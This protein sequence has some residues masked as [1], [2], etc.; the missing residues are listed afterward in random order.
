[1]LNTDNLKRQTAEKAVEYLEDNS[2][3]GLGTGSTFIYALKYIADMLNRG[4]LKNI[5]GIPSSVTTAKNAQKFGIT[6][7]TLDD[8]PRIDMTID[9][10]DEFDPRLN[11]I[12]GGGGALLRE[13]IIAQATRR[14][15]IIADGTKFSQ[16]IGSKSSLPVEVLPFA[17]KPETQFIEGLG[18]T[19]KIRTHSDGSIYKTDQNN[20]ILDC[21]FGPIEDPYELSAK[22]NDRAGIMSHG[23]FLNLASEIIMAG[24]EGIRHYT[25]P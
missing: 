11:M 21:F 8:Y 9:G 16:K 25:R 17:W 22:L 3:I 6:L 14:L 4:K 1:M 2:V 20:L 13:K 23:L 12:K 7:G 19:V 15:I 10:A 5:I 18:A 24:R